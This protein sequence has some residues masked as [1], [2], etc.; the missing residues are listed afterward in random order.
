M[1]VHKPEHVYEPIAIDVAYNHWRY[2]VVTISPWPGARVSIT[3]SIR[4]LTDEEAKVSAL[5]QWQL[6]SSLI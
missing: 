1:S 4:T 5:E 2:P 3:L 6:I